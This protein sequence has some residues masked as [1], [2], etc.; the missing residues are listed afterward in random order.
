MDP[1]LREL[2]DLFIRWLHLIAGI[3]WIGNSML[4][5][6]LD[7]NMKKQEGDPHLLGREYW[8]HGGG[9]YTVEKRTQ[10]DGT[11]PP[12]FQIFKWQSYTTWISGFFLL[13]VVYYLSSGLLVDPTVANISH[14]TGVAI[15]LGTLAG[16]FLIY[17]LLWRSPI[18][19]HQ[20]LAVAI[21]LALLFAVG[22]GLLMV[23]SPRAAFLHVGALIGTFMSGN[24]FFHII[25][26]QKKMVEKLQAGGEHD[27]NLG[28]A[29]KTRSIHNNYL[30]FPML[31]LMLSNHFPSVYGH[32]MAAVL[33]AVLILGGMATRHFMNIRYH[34]QN[35][36][37]AMGGSIA[38]TAV[39]V[40]LL[41]APP[42]PQAPIAGAEA[43]PVAF[44]EV[45]TVIT[46][47]CATCHSNAP[48][49]DVF[50]A[51]PGGVVFDTAVQ[52]Q[53][54][55]ARI[56]ARSVATTTMP[57]ANKTQM[58]PEERELL[59]RWVKAGAPIE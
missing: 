58:T 43:T 30:T 15:G 59:G 19:K 32:G 29:A 12:W 38:V 37:P 9:F 35:W 28:A 6:W 31:F 50:K 42:A 5:N 57:V 45:E 2:F 41:T 48:T 52:M 40:F 7:R 55:A 1:H 16:G 27:L 34:F 22:Y 23:L 25:P 14:G 17:D 39:A 47:R 8:L 53:A 24:V 44:T 49:D 54:Q 4:F 20:Q 56:H 11:L 33:L 46:Q 3:M 10:P 21:S 26:S 13:A 51:P 36:L 18:G